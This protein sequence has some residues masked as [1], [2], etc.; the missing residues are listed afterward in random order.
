VLPPDQ[1]F[2]RDD[3]AGFERHFRLVV[4]PELLPLQGATKLAL[5]LQAPQ[6]ALAHD[7]LEH[8]VAV[9]A[10]RLGLVHCQVRV[11]KQVARSLPASTP[12]A[13]PHAGRD[14][15]LAPPQ[16]EGRPQR[17]SDP[18]RHPRRVARA[19]Y[20]FKQDGELVS[21]EAGKRL[22][23]QHAVLQAFDDRQQ[24]LISHL[25]T[26]GVVDNL[27]V[28]QVHEQHRNLDVSPS[29]T[30]Q[31][32]LQA[33][34]EQGPV[35]QPG[36]GVVERLVGQLFL[37]LPPLGDLPLQLRVGLSE[38]SGPLPHPIFQLVVRAPQILLGV[39]AFG[40]VVLHPDEV[41]EAPT[42]VVHG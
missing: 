24:D 27:E 15:P 42:L 6:G 18:L 13:D 37:E 8:R 29:G 2:H 26:Q 22:F 23:G 7:R 14:E 36:Q 35:R 1:R 16:D 33:V 38:T 10:P 11:P 25:V 20:V 39:L 17:P 3:L 21:P 41:D 5:Q 19:R 31:G 32:E 9:P 34:E 28:V 4:E 40:D 12:E 30:L